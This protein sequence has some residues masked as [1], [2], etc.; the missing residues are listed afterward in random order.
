MSQ[1]EPT[2]AADETLAWGPGEPAPQNRDLTGKT[3]GDFLVERML[4]RGG[5]GEVYLARQVSLQRQVA[6]KV[7]R[8]DLLTKETY[9]RR[10]EAEATAVAKLNHPNIVHVYTL[11]NIDQIRFIAMEYVQ[12]TNL[13]DYITKKGALDLPLAF[14]IMKQAG[15]AIGAAGEVGLVHRDIKPENLLL[16]RKGQVKIADFGLCRD[17]DSS[18]LHLTQPGVTMGTPLYMSPE[19]AQGFLSDHRSDLYSLGVTFYHMLAGIPPFRADSPLAVAMKHLKDTPASLAVHRPD[20]PQ[21]LDRLVLKLMEK[22][23]ADRYQSA[24]EMLRDLSRVKE[25]VNAPSVVTSQVAITTTMGSANGSKPGSG[26]STATPSSSGSALLASVVSSAAHAVVHRLSIPRPGTKWL[27]ALVVVCLGAGALGGWLSRS[28]DLLAANAAEPSVPGLWI[29]PDW[30]SVPKQGGAAAQFRYAQL[31]APHD[32][33]ESAWVAVAGNYPQSHEWVAQ[34]YIQLAREL[35]RK[36]DAER[37]KSL[38]REIDRWSESKAHEKELAAIIEAGVK[39]LDM[40]PEG[41]SSAFK[42]EVKPKD[43]SDPA[44]AELGIE[45]TLHAMDV[46]SHSGAPPSFAQLQ[47]ARRE[48]TEVLFRLLQQGRGRPRPR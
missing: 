10:F 24:A 29:A 8:P 37:L 46:A 15:I 2:P 42:N 3:L 21:E 26:S 33:S 38:A 6:L 23:P 30:T 7:L 44:L 20:I 41:V 28:E 31:R 19:Q 27:I 16:T 32:E 5:M 4:G 34:A 45:V 12:G 18:N 13:R 11:G 40:D 43:L 22:N 9:L 47:A 39:A 17:Q 25:S 35:L 48:L 36:R 14:S 1:P